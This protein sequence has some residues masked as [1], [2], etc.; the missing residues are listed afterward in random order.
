MCNVAFGAG[1][2]LQQTTQTTW[3][4]IPA[5]EIEATSVEQRHRQGLYSDHL[6]HVGLSR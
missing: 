4:G 3:K 6:V 1:L 2:H 5:I